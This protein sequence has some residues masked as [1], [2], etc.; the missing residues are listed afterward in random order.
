MTRRFATPLAVCLA[1][2]ALAISVAFADD[3]ADKSRFER[4]L[5]SMLSTE[6]RQV[7]VSGLEGAL[8]SNPT[9]GRIT[10]ADHDGVWL[11]LDNVSMVW[12]RLALIRQRLDIDSFSA[13]RVQLLR[14]PH[15]RKGEGG[16]GL[17]VDVNLGALSL[18]DI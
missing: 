11:E 6:G 12:S 7:S 2:A 1:L 3:G 18:P 10:V 8:S 15:A 14:Q 4:L 9:V 16:S 5:Q 13:G 17:P